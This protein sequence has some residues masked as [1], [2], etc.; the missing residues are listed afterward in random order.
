MNHEKGAPGREEFCSPFFQM[1][2]HG[3]IV[4]EN[5]FKLFVVIDTTFFGKVVDEEVLVVVAHKYFLKIT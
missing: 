1:F 3:S 2:F 5:Q 4:S